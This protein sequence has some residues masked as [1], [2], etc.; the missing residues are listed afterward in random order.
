MT[1]LVLAFPCDCCNI[2]AVRLATKGRSDCGLSRWSTG[3]S[4]V[5][6]CKQLR[7][8]EN[9]RGST[10]KVPNTP[11]THHRFPAVALAMQQTRSGITSHLKTKLSTKPV[12]RTVP[13]FLRLLASGVLERRRR[14]I[15]VVSPSTGP[16]TVAGMPK[17]ISCVAG[18]GPLEAIESGAASSARKSVIP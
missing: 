8:R 9:I 15:L 13:S 10:T 3:I 16:H 5:C 7:A 12:L 6:Y 2:L 17:Q 4:L 18:S 11:A 1:V 14:S